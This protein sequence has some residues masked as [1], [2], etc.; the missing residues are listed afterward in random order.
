MAAALG[1]GMTP[2]LAE[3]DKAKAPSVSR[4][5][6]PADLDS[7]P[8][9]VADRDRAAD[10]D[11]VVA[12][13]LGAVKHMDDVEVVSADASAKTI[14]LKIDGE[15]QTLPFTHKSTVALK[16]VKP[17]DEVRIFYSDPDADGKPNAVSALVITEAKKIDVDSDDAR[18]DA[19]D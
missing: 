15:D 5:A 7:A 16:V 9:P 17:G 11:T 1:L 3:D 10:D 2:A 8:A 14:T 18:D 6:P 4:E 19:R 13:A 12:G